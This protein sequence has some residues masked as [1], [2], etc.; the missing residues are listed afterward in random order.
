MILLCVL[1]LFAALFPATAYAGNVTVS[2]YSNYNYFVTFGSDGTWKGIQTPNHSIVET[3]AVAYCLQPAK[4]TP[5]NSGYTE[6]MGWSAYDET[7]RLGIQAILENGY[8]NYN[9]GF[10]DGEARYAT[11]NA[12]RFW[13]A[14]RGCDGALD[15]M[16]LTRFSEFFRGASGYEDLFDWC[17]YLLDCARNGSVLQHNAWMTEPVV[18]DY[19]DCFDV[20]TTVTLEN[21]N[22]GYSIDESLLPSGTD[23]YGYSGNSGDNL[24]LRIPADQ[25][26]VSFDLSITAYDNRTPAS[27]VYYGPDSSNMQRIVSYTLSTS[28]L[29]A[30]AV[31][32]VSLEASVSED[33]GTV[34][35][36][37]TDSVTGEPIED[38]G[39][40]IYGPNGFSS[41][42]TDANGIVEFTFEPGSYSYREGD[43]PDGYVVD[44]SRYYFTITAGEVT[45]IHVE[46][47]PLPQNDA[48]IEIIKTDESGN[49]LAGAEI[50]LYDSSQNFISSVTTGSNGKATFSDLATDTYYYKEITAPSGYVLDSVMREIVIDTA[51]ETVTA[52]LKNT[53]ATGT[54]YIAKSD[55]D[56]GAALSGV[57][58]TV[59]DSDYN[60]VTKGTTNTNGNLSISD[61][62]LGSY[63]YRETKAKDGYIAD[64]T[65]YPFD[66]TY[67]GQLISVAVR[68]KADIVKGSISIKKVDAYG[69]TLPGAVFS[70]E[71]ST[72][73]ST[74]SKVSEV[75]SD[76]TGLAVFSD[77]VCGDTLYRVT[78]TKAPPGHS[79]LAGVVYEGK[80]NK[81]SP[82]LSF[83]AC[84]CAIPMLPFTGTES[85]LMTF[86]FNVSK[87]FSR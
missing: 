36:I 53:K 43:P 7:T 60:Y 77:L 85:I 37:K 52:T 35:F 87:L 9:G 58:F 69:N 1:L 61:L 70:L 73:G 15:W 11:A 48:V 4:D 84:D 59:Y 55:Y 5:S 27:V 75:T 47:T 79:L 71:S 3:G 38:V 86:I 28:A 51:G 74:W 13:V 63:Y 30:E 50:G 32:T 81:D 12:I 56:T 42:W 66:L 24:T 46:N 62:P 2:T 21:C 83:T 10:Y 22:W 33:M 80:L 14:E 82:D 57:E 76:E 6:G 20:T 54:L 17:M 64:D 23:I 18:T 31:Q 19:G 26:G 8:P 41:N 39:F 40:W 29:A 68:N 78:E 34:R 45:E 67:D 49:A 44:D 72:D 65:Y 25:A 16:D